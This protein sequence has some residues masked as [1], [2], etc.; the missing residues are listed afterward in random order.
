VRGSPGNAISVVIRLPAR[1]RS[2][3]AEAA[4]SRHCPHSFQGFA[5]LRCEKLPAIRR[6]CSIDR[7]TSFDADD[8]FWIEAKIH[9]P[10]VHER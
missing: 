4:S 7:H 5:R 8:V 3:V 10:K 2:L 1:G 9:C 6:E